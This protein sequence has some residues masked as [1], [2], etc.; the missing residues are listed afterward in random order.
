MG[1]ADA[2]LQQP[3]ELLLPGDVL[4]VAEDSFCFRDSVLPLRRAKRQ[5]LQ[6][7]SVA[8]ILT[9]PKEFANLLRG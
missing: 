7:M 2:P 8:A 3:T 1:I 9:L 5:C 4:N 6:M